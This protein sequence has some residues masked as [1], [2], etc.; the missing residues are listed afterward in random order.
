MR[1][2]AEIAGDAITDIRSAIEQGMEQRGKVASG[3]TIRSIQTGV[4]AATGYAMGVL[5]ADHQWRYVG[6]GRGPGLMPPVES[7]RSWIEARG[8]DLSPWA[9]AK[10]I[11]R[12]GTFDFR[13]KRPNV[14]LSEIDGWVENKLTAVEDAVAE[15]GMDRTVEVIKTNLKDG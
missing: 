6:N 13:A 10:K 14:F 3:S 15:L 5:S 11:A 2:L 4:F 7:I 12:E 8:L 1:T 9:V